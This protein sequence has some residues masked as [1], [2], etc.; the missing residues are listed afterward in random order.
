MIDNPDSDRHA[1]L[2]TLAILPGSRQCRDKRVAG[3][4]PPPCA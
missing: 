2:K 4:R 1:K 3:A